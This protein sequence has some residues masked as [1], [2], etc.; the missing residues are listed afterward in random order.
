MLLLS[1][2]GSDGVSQLCA[3]TVTSFAISP[4]QH[5]P[6]SP[7]PEE[8]SKASEAE[9]NAAGWSR[10]WFVGL[11]AAQAKRERA[12][13]WARMARF[14]QGLPAWGYRDTIVDMVKNH[15]VGARRSQ[16]PVRHGSLERHGNSASRPSS[17]QRLHVVERP[18]SP[19]AGTRINGRPAIYRVRARAGLSWLRRAVV[20]TCRGPSWFVMVC[21]GLSWHRSE[22]AE[23]RAGS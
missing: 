3:P 6:T 19:D 15:Q 18:S 9:V 17:R 2:F 4:H 22:R 21:H 10:C 1:V 14:R 20:V 23:E 7:P 8:S 11:S 13:G 12:P 5:P 16:P